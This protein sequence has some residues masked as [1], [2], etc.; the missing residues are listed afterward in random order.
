M[1]TNT[2]WKPYVYVLTTNA[3][4]PSFFSDLNDTNGTIHIS[5]SP[6]IRL[7]ARFNEDEAKSMASLIETMT[8]LSLN[9]VC[10]WDIL[11]EEQVLLLR[12]FYELP[13]EWAYL[14]GPDIDVPDD[15]PDND[16]E[17]TP[18]AEK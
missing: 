3:S 1:K 10:L 2:T 16:P 8:G 9:V 11:S 13:N 5:C 17:E 14:F 6:D 18:E 12:V 15:I 7:A 4:S